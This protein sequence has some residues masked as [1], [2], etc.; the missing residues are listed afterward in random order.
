MEP[1]SIIYRDANGIL[2]DADITHGF[3]VQDVNKKYL[4]KDLNLTRP[5]NTSAYAAAD[6]IGDKTSAPV[7]AA[8]T[9]SGMAQVSGNGGR[10]RGITAYTDQ[11]TCVAHLRVHL[12]N[13]SAITLMN[14]NDP[15]TLLNA[16]RPYQVAMITLPP[17]VTEGTGSNLAYAQDLTLDIPYLCNTTNLYFMLETL[18]AFTPASGQNFYLKLL[19]ELL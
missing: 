1:G 2:R 3:P 11:T 12:F 5:A 7:L 9:A 6:L 15:F 18:D 4:I 16:N 19:V 10:I 17:L 13:N 8:I 14:D